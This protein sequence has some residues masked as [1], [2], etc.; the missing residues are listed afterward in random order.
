MS[1][2]KLPKLSIFLLN[3]LRYVFVLLPSSCVLEKKKLSCA[4]FIWNNSVEM[5]DELHTETMKTYDQDY[6]TKP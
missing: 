2:S 1:S 3:L 4:L 6:D 5:R